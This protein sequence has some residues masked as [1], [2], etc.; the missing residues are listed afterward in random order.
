VL[1]SWRSGDRYVRLDDGSL[2][3]LPVRWLERHGHAL[4]DLQ[5]AHRTTRKLGAWHVWMATE[6]LE[7]HGGAERWLER[8]RSQAVIRREPPAGLR[9]TLRPYQRDGLDWL[10]FLRDHGLH[11]VLADEM[12]LGK[13]VQTLAALLEGRGR[14][15]PAS[16][17]VAPTSV[18]SVWR[19][20]A[21]RFAPELRVRVWHGPD[22]HRE[23]L[24]EADLV[25]TSYPL[26]RRDA[27]ALARVDWSW[28]VLDE[29]RHIKNPASLTARAARR[30]RARHRLI[31]SGTPLEND[32]VEL[33]SLFQF[34]MP[35][36]LGRRTTFHS[37]YAVA[38]SRRDQP[39][40]R[41]ALDELAKR[42][43]PFVLRRRKRDVAAE[44]PPKTEITQ[45]VELSAR[46]R[47][48]YESVRATVRARLAAR[49]EEGS[50][51]AGALV[52]EGLTRL[53][54]ACCH[55]ALLPFPE[56]RAVR[57][58]AKLEALLERLQ[59]A[60][61]CG[62][63]AIVFSQWVGL[64]DLAAARLTEQGV[65]FGRLDGRTAD[66]AGVV[67]RFQRPDGPPV[68]LVSVMA[69]G[70]GLTLTAAD[71]VVHLDPWWNPA[72]EDQAT[73]RAH[74]IGQVRPLTVVRLVA[75][76]TVEE[77]VLALQQHKRSL[78]DQ[79][80]EGPTLDVAGLTTDVL[81]ELLSG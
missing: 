8:T 58:S 53:R 20:E 19:E 47:A 11:G 21:A 28:V 81:L 5:E 46:E 15:D 26:L 41:P 13:T 62:S 76:D 51:P 2:A 73:D 70:T 12:G 6:L 39:G 3:E 10:C 78:F 72:V 60:I 29:A 48:L 7:E 52:L 30:L 44:L 34:L 67:R 57:H 54:Q 27:E 31:L 4:I 14:T 9:A 36:L 65:A 77:R 23:T 37:R 32:L 55:P 61:P 74:R 79:V 66:R 59:E 35:G 50:V 69:G 38:Q 25:V 49:G 63:R 56:A 64:L 42:V 22:R 16:L 18:L 33:W 1:E 43:R 45:R 80:V 17:V 40:Q 75:A 68:L 24:A 71:L